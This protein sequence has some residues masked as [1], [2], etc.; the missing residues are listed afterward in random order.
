ML[1]KVYKEEALKVLSENRDKHIKEFAGQMQGWKNAMEQYGKDL[2]LWSDKASEDV[3]DKQQAPDKPKEPPK[4]VSY[5]D[6][7]DRFLELVAANVT[8]VI[9]IDEHEYDQ[10]IKNKFSWSS[11]FVFNSSVYNNAGF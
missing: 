2:S 4:P 10:I 11:K 6:S 1:I 5:V 8:E 3:F 7:Y 9:E